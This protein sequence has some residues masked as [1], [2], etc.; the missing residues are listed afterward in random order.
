M[1]R[2]DMR[3]CAAGEDSAVLA[4]TRVAMLTDLLGLSSWGRAEALPVAAVA[5][6][7]TV[8]P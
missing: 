8:A 5:A 2:S 6:V 4:Q 7:A 1:R 3:Y